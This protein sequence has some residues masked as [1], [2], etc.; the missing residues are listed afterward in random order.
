ME[1]VEVATAATCP[2]VSFKQSP[3]S[4]DAEANQS[5]LSP[6]FRSAAAMAGWD[7]EALLATLVVEDTP[8]R[9]SHHKKR[10]RS[11]QKFISSPPTTRSTRKRRSALDPIPCIV[12]C[13]DDSDEASSQQEAVI[14]E[15]GLE[16]FKP[17][18]EKEG[19]EGVSGERDCG[20]SIPCM[21]L[22]RDELSCA[23]C[24]EICYEPS[25]TTCGHSFCKKC[26]KNSAN[27][28]GKRCPKCRQLIS[29]GR[30]CTVNTVLW[31]TIQLLF[32]EEVEARKKEAAAA[33]N[34][35]SEEQVSNFGLKLD[36]ILRDSRR[37][38]RGASAGGAFRSAI[39]VLESGGGGEINS[40]RR[41][42]SRQFQDAALALRL[43]REEFLVAF[44]NSGGRSR[45]FN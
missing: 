25:T 29:N 39:E 4:V 15:K 37:S 38:S 1:A 5:I 32:P 34:A 3:G 30:S 16:S 42:S 8:M 35:S 22:L 45:R 21:D 31:N 44:R 7:E 17:K 43:Q 28:C 20:K 9:D 27:K 19:D 23:V 12:L 14:V 24:L 41:L 18:E 26:L 2:Q 6:G 13:L 33:L 40:G 11:R 36:K 10:S